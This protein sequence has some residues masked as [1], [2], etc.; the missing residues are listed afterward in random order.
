MNE[1]QQT[2]DGKI[3]QSQDAAAGKEPDR[4]RTVLFSIAGLLASVVAL[5]LAAIPAV[6]YDRPLENP[7]AEKKLKEERPPEPE[8]EREGGITLKYKSFSVNFGGKEAE[9]KPEPLPEPESPADPV[10]WY[11]ISA[12]GCA[13]IGIVLAGVG[14]VREKQTAVTVCTMGCCV[15]AFT[16]QYVA[17]GIAAGVAVAVLLIIL[18]FAGAVFGG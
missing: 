10:R 9:E 3:P 5:A 17:V 13:L 8:P 12:M 2:T 7:F 18:Y 6:V 15:A 1:K 4:Q 16:W 14:Q 11:T